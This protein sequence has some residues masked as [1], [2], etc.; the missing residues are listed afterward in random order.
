MI[1]TPKRNIPGD[2][3]NGLWN[4]KRTIVNILAVVQRELANPSYL[5]CS[6]RAPRH[7]EQNNKKTLLDTS[8]NLSA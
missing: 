1:G 6:L 7:R 2:R 5:F 3:K 8:P 4:N